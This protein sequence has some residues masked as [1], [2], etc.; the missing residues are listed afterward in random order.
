MTQLNSTAERIQKVLANRGLG[1][2]REIERWIRQGRLVI[3]NKPAQLG[4]KLNGDEAVFLDGRLIRAQ[5]KLQ[6]IVE[7]LAYHKPI[8]EITTRKDPEGRATMYDR[9]KAPR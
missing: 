9:F 5:K 4:D 8:G 2:R 1:S 7:C 3:G 6:P